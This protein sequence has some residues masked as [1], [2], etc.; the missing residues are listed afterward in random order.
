MAHNW[1]HI[2]LEMNKL[3][4]T[5]RPFVFLIDFDFQSPK[6]WSWDKSASQL[7]W[8]TPKH[9]NYQIQS[10]P[11]ADYHWQA[12]PVTYAQYQKAFNLVQSHIHNGDSYLLNL[13][14]PSKVDTNLDLETI[15]HHSR[16]PYKVYLKDHFVCFSPEIFVRIENGEI[17]SFPMKG[18]IDAKLPNAEFQLRNSPKEMAEHH[19]IVD[20]IRNDLSR[21]AEQVEVSRFCYIDK[22]QSGQT[23]LLQ[24]S[25]EITGKLP[26]NYHAHLGDI[27][28]KLLPAGS[29]CGAPKKKTVEIIQKAEG[30]HRGYYTGIFG[31]FDG[32][33]VDSCVLIRY[34]EQQN[35]QLVYKSGG[36]ITHLSQCED[37]YR[38]LVNKVY[39]PITRNH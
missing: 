28:E 10:S 6:I 7:L 18:T 11:I 9:G 33:N 26:E 36:G 27:F 22:I 3:G 21:V 12:K 8:K 24:M 20:L 32:T 35:G 34:V 17:S 39:V 1:E 38:E 4:K 31:I 30:Y 14:M 37:E 2:I 15:F 29:I 16:A 19:T 13:T 23:D 5:R 25:S